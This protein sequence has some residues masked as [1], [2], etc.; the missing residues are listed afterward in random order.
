MQHVNFKY[1]PAA[2]QIEIGDA[3]DKYDYKSK[4]FAVNQDSSE[5]QEFDLSPDLCCG[6]YIKINLL[7]KP[8]V[9]ST[10]EQYYVA[11]SYVGIQ[12]MKLD[13]LVIDKQLEKQPQGK[14][15]EQKT[16]EQPG[17]Q[18]NLEIDSFKQSLYNLILKSNKNIGL[19][20]NMNNDGLGQMGEPKQ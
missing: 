16:S 13:A 18:P 11:M 8:H 14:K 17:E 19:N 10:D 15:E 7:G 1:A 9:Q 12:G 3:P 5:E 6:R 20:Q 2:V 4:I